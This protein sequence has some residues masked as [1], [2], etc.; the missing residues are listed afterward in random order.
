MPSPP[1][2][3]FV[4]TTYIGQFGHHYDNSCL[5]GINSTDS[6]VAEHFQWSVPDQKRAIK[7]MTREQCI[8]ILTGILTDEGI[9]T[10][11][12]NMRGT[13]DLRRQT[14]IISTGFVCVKS[15]RIQANRY[16]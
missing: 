3:R 9:A 11:K 5:R 4:A 15:P 7:K 12:L 13:T 1:K 2:T 14:M 8:H 10:L 6:F 16:V